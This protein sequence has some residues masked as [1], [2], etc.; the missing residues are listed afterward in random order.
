MTGDAV[1]AVWRGG[2]W[3]E[4]TRRRSRRVAPREGGAHGATRSEQ[5]LP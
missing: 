2:A 4:A 5:E 1:S 3:T